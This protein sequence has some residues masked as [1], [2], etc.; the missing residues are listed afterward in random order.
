M[1][2]ANC[3]G[4]CIVEAALALVIFAA[5]VLVLLD[6]ASPK[7]RVFRTLSEEVR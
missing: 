6:W 2:P 3:R 7:S 5:I 4:Q 1:A